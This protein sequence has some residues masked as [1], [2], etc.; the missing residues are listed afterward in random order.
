MH[1]V[2]PSDAITLLTIPVSWD[3]QPSTCEQISKLFGL[4]ESQINV[5]VGV[6]PKVVLKAASTP[7]VLIAASDSG[8]EAELQLAE[9]MYMSVRILGW[10]LGA[11][12]MLHIDGVKIAFVHGMYPS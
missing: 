6:E 3:R 2:I 7:L 5:R 9:K 10:R 4:K 12:Y 1:V 11:Y 8:K